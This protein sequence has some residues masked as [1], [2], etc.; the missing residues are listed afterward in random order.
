MSGLHRA[1]ALSLTHAVPICRC[2]PG[3]RSMSAAL[4]QRLSTTCA[5]W[6]VLLS[7]LAYAPHAQAPAEPFR[8]WSHAAMS[9][10][11]DSLVCARLH[12]PDAR[13]VF[14]TAGYGRLARLQQAHGV[15]S[16]GLDEVGR[17]LPVPSSE[18]EIA[19]MSLTEPARAL[20]G[21]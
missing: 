8:D 5:L 9:R 19:V 15:S 14:A 16:C 17:G 18:R 12:S 7:L 2:V 11:A 3:S 6:L 13:P 1:P 21:D 10:P 4:R 20:P